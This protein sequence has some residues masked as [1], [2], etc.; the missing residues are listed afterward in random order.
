MELIIL[1]AVVVGVVG[2]WI[3]KEGK[4]EQAGNHPLQTFTKKLDVNNDGKIDVKDAAAVVTEV[5][6]TVTAVADV[7]KDGR[8]D[9]EDA[10]V[11]VEATKKA[12]RKAKAKVE[13]TVAKAKK[14]R[15]PKAK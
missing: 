6:E 15:K 1:L 3:W 14:S 13:E 7:N 11:V 12:G 9:V 4:S 8:V 2:W 5:K 10:K